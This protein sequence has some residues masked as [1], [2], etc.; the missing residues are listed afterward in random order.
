[1]GDIDTVWLASKSPRRAQLLREVFPNIVCQGIEGVDEKPPLGLVEYQVLEIC[2]KKAR[3]ADLESQI[4]DYD[5]VIVCDT[6]L[7][8]PDDPML[9]IGK[10]SDEIEAAMMLDSLSGRRHQVWSATGIKKLSQWKFYCESSLVEINTL[11]DEV[12]VELIL[13]KLWHGKA[14]GYDLAG[15]MGQWAKL[16]D[17]SESTVLGIASQALIDLQQ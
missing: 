9:S 2:K 13:S 8:D 16:I 11:S 4:N 3:A 17:G 5:V 1:M 14:G 6:M 7:C 12:L 10:P 15:P